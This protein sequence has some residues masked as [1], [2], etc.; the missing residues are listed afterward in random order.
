MNDQ[1]LQVN[2]L[3]TYFFTASGT[4]KAVDGVSFTMNRGQ[5]MGIVGE[6][7]SGKSVTA[8]SLIR[9]L[10]KTGSI[11]DGEV[12]FDGHDMRRIANRELLKL[13][14]SEI[15]MIFQDPMTSLDPVF[16]IGDQMIE[17]IRTH[18][19]LSQQ[20]AYRTAV[21]MLHLVG[22]PE[23]ESR[24]NAYPHEL[25]GGMC[26]RVIIAMAISCQPKFIIADEPTT[27]LDVTVQAQILGLLK[28][29]R[30]EMGVSI[31]MITHNLGIVWEMCDTVMVMYGGTT[32]EYTEMAKLYANPLH[33]YTWGLLDSMPRLSAP[34]VEELKAIPGTPP[35]LRLTG[36]CCAFYNRCPYMREICAKEVPPLLEVEPGH[37]VA[38]HRQNGDKTLVRGEVNQDD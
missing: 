12:I 11:V 37:L 21:E 38:C 34:P 27:A 9:L 20:E 6:S 23:P 14:G 18:K 5:I 28:K 8:S 17:L 10:P 29:L 13:R 35:D 3:K 33:P 15:S 32:V 7:G 31:L 2:N 4:A 16:K 22:I 36:G 25:S 24:M 1:I 30:D 19:N 26:Q